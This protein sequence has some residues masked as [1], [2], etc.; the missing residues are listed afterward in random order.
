M[1]SEPDK[2]ATKGGPGLDGAETSMEVSPERSA[3]PAPAAAV[4]LSKEVQE[5]IG[6]QL[7][8]E[9]DIVAE[10]PTFLGDPAI[11]EQFD[12]H[13]ARLETRERAHTEA[14]EAVEKALEEIVLD[15]GVDESPDDQTKA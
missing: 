1:P 5:H 2:N 10:K 4:V 13:L 12:W 8:T 6:Q 15:L 11:P 14:I 9:Y 7:R 3:G